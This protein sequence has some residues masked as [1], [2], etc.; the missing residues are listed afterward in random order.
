MKQKQ[1]FDG[2]L[3]LYLQETKAKEAK[4]AKDQQYVERQFQRES[5]MQ[6]IK[7]KKFDEELLN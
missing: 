2:L 3:K 6:Y 5:K 7:E 1:E 4:K